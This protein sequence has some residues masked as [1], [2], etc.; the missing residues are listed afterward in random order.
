MSVDNPSFDE[1]L[2]NAAHEN[3]VTT[4]ENGENKEPERETKLTEL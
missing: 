4:K 3:G 2:K 1:S